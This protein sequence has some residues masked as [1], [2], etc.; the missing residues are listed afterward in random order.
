MSRL[1]VFTWVHFKGEQHIGVGSASW[2]WGQ[3]L[4]GDN[5]VS[6]LQ[7]NAGHGTA[8]DTCCYCHCCPRVVMPGPNLSLALLRAEARRQHRLMLAPQK[9]QVGELFLKTNNDNLAFLNASQMKWWGLA[10]CAC[11]VKSR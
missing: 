5:P 2:F 9:N 7:E 1:I 3:T 11:T 8:V 10:Q 4:T 6:V